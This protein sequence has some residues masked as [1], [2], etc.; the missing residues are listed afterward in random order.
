MSRSDGAAARPN[1]VWVLLD[2]CRA[3]VLGCYGHPFV[4]TPNIDRLGRRGVVFDNAYCQNPVCVPSRVSFMSGMYCHQ[5][6]VYGNGVRPEDPGMKPEDSLLLRA[7][8]E[9]GYT[10]ANVGKVHLRLPPEEAGFDLN[11][12]LRHGEHFDG[13][14]HTRIP[15]DYPPELPIRQF[16]AEG[17]PRP[18][19]YATETCSKE[20]TYC[21]VMTS[22]AARIWHEHDFGAAPLFLRLSLDR[23]H[24]PVASPP[25]FDTLYAGPTRLSPAPVRER[26]P[27]PASL[28]ELIWKRHWDRFTEEER[29]RIRSYYYGLVTHVDDEL[30]QLLRTVEASPEA[31]NT[32]VVLSADHGCMLGEHGLQVKGPHYYR[33]TARVP[34]ILALPG[35][36]P[37]GKR[38]HGMVELVDL[39]PTFCEL[40]GIPL[41]DRAAG[42]SLLPVM[43]RDAPAREHVFAEQ[44]SDANLGTGEHWAAVRTERY[45]YTY[46]FDTG[47]ATLFDLAGDPGERDNLMLRNPPAAVVR[48]LDARMR[49]AMETRG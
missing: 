38:A 17:F 21:R 24:T 31:D 28:Q 26:S 48:D 2:Q 43:Q 41:P 6:G 44:K 7:L 11:P 45:S 19:I 18:I 30:G 13:V 40:T 47:V 5:T 9:A 33:E 36:L 3:D 16:D 14:P 8:G 37:A 39:L 42:R 35:R 15:D 25:P 27:L 12:V 32:L 46:Y 23:P 4:R 1:I 10:R 20:R 34:L 49:R 22:T 29:L